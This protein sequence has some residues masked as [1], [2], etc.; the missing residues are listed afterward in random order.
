MSET[1]GNKTISRK[2][3]SQTKHVVDSQNCKTNK[4]PQ[5]KLDEDSS[6]KDKTNMPDYLNFSLHQ[7]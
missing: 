3:Y 2:F 4:D 6:S 7:D 1:V 5:A